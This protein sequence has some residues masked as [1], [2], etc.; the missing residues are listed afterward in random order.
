MTDALEGGY[1]K[2]YRC[3]KTPITR[4]RFCDN[5][6]PVAAT[7]FVGCAAYRPFGSVIIV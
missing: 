1:F 2:T 4:P 5:G 6:K 7:G 3:V